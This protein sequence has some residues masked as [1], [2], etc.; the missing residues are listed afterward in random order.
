MAV[1]ALLLVPIRGASG[2]LCFLMI[3]LLGAGDGAA[4]AAGAGAGAGAGADSWDPRCCLCGVLPRLPQVL[5]G[6][7]ECALSP[8]G[9]ILPRNAHSS[10]LY[11]LLP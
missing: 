11:P 5:M 2:T 1:H 3:F 6:L 7:F 9:A 4:A 8:F 10:S